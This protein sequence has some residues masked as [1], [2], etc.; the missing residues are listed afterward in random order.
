MA[1]GLT[2]PI[3]RNAQCIPDTPATHQKE[4]FKYY[5]PICMMYHKQI[6]KATCCGQY[7]CENCVKDMFPGEKKVKIRKLPPIPCPYCMTNPLALKKVKRSDPVKFYGD[8]PSVVEA[9]R[10]KIVPLTSPIRA[11]MSFDEIRR[12]AIRYDVTMGGGE[13]AAGGTLSARTSTSASTSL[14]HIDDSSTRHEFVG[15]S[16]P[17]NATFESIPLHRRPSSAPLQQSSA[18]PEGNPLSSSSLA[19]IV[20]GGLPMFRIRGSVDSAP[21]SSRSDGPVH[22]RLGSA[23]SA[24]SQF[25]IRRRRRP[26][27]ARHDL[28]SGRPP[29][30]P[31]RAAQ[32]LMSSSVRS[33]D[34]WEDGTSIPE[35]DSDDERLP[36]SPH[37]SD[38]PQ[39]RY[40]DDRDH[41]DAAQSI[42]CAD[43]HI[44][45]DHS[46]DSVHPEASSAVMNENVPS[47][48]KHAKRKEKKGSSCCTIL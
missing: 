44:H 39:Q 21:I 34:A 32:H 47:H 17:V 37:E 15:S 13:T 6:T 31:R 7:I 5:C 23:I 22:H 16:S 41:E 26:D 45:N 35:G 48:D 25:S 43:D 14:S 2:T 46:V 19:S 40:D 8:S 9:K 36:Q 18:S 27:S 29:L 3:S 12:K 30:P 38:Q 28:A 1:S 10:G 11:G 24:S 42:A 20:S 33:G 4:I